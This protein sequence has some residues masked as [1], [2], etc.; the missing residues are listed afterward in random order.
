M[1]NVHAEIRMT[2]KGVWNFVLPFWPVSHALGVRIT[3]APRMLRRELT[4]H[5]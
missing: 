3:G 5:M 2:Q 4:Y 1:N